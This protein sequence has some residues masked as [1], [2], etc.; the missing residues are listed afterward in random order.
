MEI[1]YDSLVEEDWFKN[2]NKELNLSNSHKIQ[3][4]GN[5]PIIDNLLTYDKPDIILTKDK[6]PVL[7]V[8]KMKEVPTGHN[9]FQRAARLARAAENKIPAIYFFPFKAKKHGKF[10]NICYLNLRLLE[11]F[12]KMWKIHNSPILAVNWICDQDGELVDD[13]SEDES[14]KFILE[15]YINS[16][17]DRSCQI[18]QE[19]RIEMIKEYNERLLLPRG[20]IYKNPPPSVPIKKT[21]DFLDNL[22]F[23]IDKEIKHSLMKREESVIYKIGLNDS[24][25][26]R[27]D[28]YTGSALIY[29]YLYCRKAINPED[30]YRNLIIYFPKISFSKF[31]EKFPNDKTKSSNWYISANALVFCDGIKL[32]R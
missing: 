32:I 11:A 5:I 19:L 28:P 12:E 23:S 9:P 4:K 7:V 26:K 8:E 25:P 22:E 29:D 21:K 31:K 14:L 13:G 15:K 16:N 3:L 27:Q 2:L 10:S 20:M 17:F 30:K 18:F 6:K 1:Y 24:T